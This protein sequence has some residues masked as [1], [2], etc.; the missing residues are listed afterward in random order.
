MIQQT[1]N[2]KTFVKTI[3]DIAYRNSSVGNV[4]DDFLLLTLSAL[5]FGRAENV[6][7]EVI[8]RYHEQDVPKFGVA[9]GA[10]FSSY[11]ENVTA[12]GG[13]CDVLGSFFEE[14]N[15]K[16]GRDA[17]GQFFTPESVCHLMAKIT[18]P[19]PFAK[20]ITVMEPSCGSGRNLLAIDRL[21]PTNRLNAFYVACD[22]DSRCVK[23][24]TLNMFMHGMRG[25]VI[26]MDTLR[27]EV[28]GG[29]RVYFA[30][31]GLGIQQIS[32]YECMKYLMRQSEPEERQAEETP[33]PVEFTAA[34]IKTF[35]TQIQL[36]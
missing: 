31:T 36:F 33:E 22:I 24:C 5:S 16:F 10:L 32:K 14:H 11:N 19:E 21:S 15:G 27:L 17:L 34:Q 23:M 29:Y 28:W 35:P 25:V 3:E 6:Y 4:F 9:L 26:H 13:W 7:K 1:Q 30:E 8:S 2:Y 18:A 12:D 20:D